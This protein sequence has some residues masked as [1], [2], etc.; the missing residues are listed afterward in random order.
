VWRLIH[1]LGERH[2]LYPSVYRFDVLDVTETEVKQL[3]EAATRATCAS[4]LES[5]AEVVGRLRLDGNVMDM[6][7]FE[8]L[9]LRGEIAE[10]PRKSD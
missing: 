2:K 3:T 7:V 1:T 6:A 4:D 8:A 10:P 5:V 9:V